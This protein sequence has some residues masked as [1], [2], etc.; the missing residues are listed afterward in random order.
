MKLHSIIYIKTFTIIF[1]C[2]LILSLIMATLLS[3]IQL[4][5]IFYTISS[6]ILSSLVVMASSIYFFKK[7]PSNCI[8]HA[9]IFIIIYLLITI[10][11]QFDYLSGFTLIL[12]PFSFLL[13][14]TLLSYLSNKQMH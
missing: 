7:I 12:R 9:L 4:P 5:M 2:Y 3:F 1:T 8:L 14:I 6:Q 10:A 13:P 11:L